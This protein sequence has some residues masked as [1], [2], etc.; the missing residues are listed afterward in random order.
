MSVGSWNGE[1]ARVDARSPAL[2]ARG[3]E[4]NVK[5]VTRVVNTR[6]E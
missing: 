5:R 3:K 4:E 1:I 2:Q 6:K